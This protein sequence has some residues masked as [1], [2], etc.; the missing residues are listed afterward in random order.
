M[1]DKLENNEKEYNFLSK[2]QK[3]VEEKLQQFQKLYEEVAKAEEA[4][5]EKEKDVLK[6]VIIFPFIS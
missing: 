5:K 3:L 6:Y 2:N 1:S 4:E